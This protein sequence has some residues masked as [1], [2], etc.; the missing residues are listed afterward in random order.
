[1]RIGFVLDWNTE[2]QSAIVLARNMFRELAFLMNEKKT[3]T[4]TG[5]SKNFLGIGDI[6]QHFDVVHFPIMTG[7]KFLDDSAFN[8]KNLIVSPS[9]IDEVVYGEEV[10]PDKYR[11]ARQEPIIEYEVFRWKQNVEKVK[12][13]H[14]VSKSDSHDMN[15]Y[16]GVPMDKMV[17]IPHG[18][19][20]TVF[21]PPNDKKEIRKSVLKYFKIPDSN[22]FI[23]VSEYNW[24]R[25]NLLRLLDAFEEAKKSGM[26]HKLILVGDLHPSIL[27]RVKIAQD[28][29]SL[30]WVSNSHL[31]QLLQG[32]DALLLPSIHEGFGLPLVESMSCGTPCI[33]SNIHSPPEVVGKGGILVDPR[34]TSEIK[35]AIIELSKNEKLRAELSREAIKRSNDFSWKKNALS[36]LEVYEKSSPNI[37]SWDFEKNFE[38]SASRTLSTVCE[39]FPDIKQHLIEHLLQFDFTK[40]SQWALEE[41]LSNEKTKHFL[42]PLENWLRD[43]SKI[44][45]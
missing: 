13:V 14:V 22:Y 9:G 3:F 45:D 10:F 33:T 8:C 35:N 34:E 38:V 23:H 11:W 29:E 28:I 40:L 2:N 1:M 42:L 4:V 6:N 37:Q 26:A 21:S 17:V 19:D 32:A 20:H 16:L 25:K 36:L 27:K 31:V 43:K 44:N 12:A 39:L 30:S 7:Y 15:E 5:I 24:A 41:G 18:V